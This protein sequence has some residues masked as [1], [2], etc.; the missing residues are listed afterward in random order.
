M[1][2]QHAKIVKNK[3]TYNETQETYIKTNEEYIEKVIERVT[4]VPRGKQQKNN[5]FT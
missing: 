1:H 2:T 5:R 4:T 3:T